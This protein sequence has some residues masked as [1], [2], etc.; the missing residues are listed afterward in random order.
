[1]AKRSN[2]IRVKFLVDKDI[3]YPM[4]KI[5]TK[6]GWII[7]SFM[8]Q[9]TKY[10]SRN[11]PSVCDHWYDA[12]EILRREHKRDYRVY[13][14]SDF[15]AYQF[16]KQ[17]PDLDGGRLLFRDLS[18]RITGNLK[19]RYNGMVGE[20]LVDRHCL[21]IDTSVFKNP[22]VAKYT[23]ME[24][25]P[26]FIDLVLY[27]HCEVDYNWEQNRTKIIEYRFFN[28]VNGLEKTIKQRSK[29][30]QE[31]VNEAFRIFEE[32]KQRGVEL[33]VEMLL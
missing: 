17:S 24:D 1:M 14:M 3:V 33:M 23:Q 13:D 16:D 15:T 28:D 5:W 29:S 20:S 12:H 30:Q 18:D 2:D 27:D 4:V 9:V 25:A 7:E 6:N 31:G 19:I 11:A 26:E 21:K 22:A 32:Y 10:R 8:D